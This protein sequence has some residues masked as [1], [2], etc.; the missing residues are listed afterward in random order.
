MKCCD[1][2]E[3]EMQTIGRGGGEQ[4]IAELDASIR[5]IREEI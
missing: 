4:R 3:E 2:I 1:R 5:R